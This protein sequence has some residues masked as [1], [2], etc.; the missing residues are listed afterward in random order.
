MI[1]KQLTIPKC[2][3]PRLDC[4]DFE[5]GKL[6]GNTN[7]LLESKADY[8]WIES[9]ESFCPKIRTMKEIM[10]MPY[11]GVVDLLKSSRWAVYEARK[12]LQEWIPIEPEYEHYRCPYCRTAETIFPDSRGKLWKYCPHCGKRVGDTE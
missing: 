2:P 11:M 5:K 12:K 7:E 10:H 3:Y 4:K 9:I 1:P 6:I 8:V